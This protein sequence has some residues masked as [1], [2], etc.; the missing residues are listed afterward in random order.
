MI[1]LKKKKKAQ[2]DTCL[3]YSLVQSDVLISNQYSLI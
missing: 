1:S 3:K 2:C